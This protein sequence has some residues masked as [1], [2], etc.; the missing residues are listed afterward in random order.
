MFVASI[1]I[2]ILLLSTAIADQL[3]PSNEPLHWMALISPEFNNTEGWN[4]T[5]AYIANRY[6]LTSGTCVQNYTKF[7]IR[8]GA[9]YVYYHHENKNISK[10]EFIYDRILRTNIAYKHDSSDKKLT[11]LLLEDDEPLSLKAYI[12]PIALPPQPT[13]VQLND[14]LD[15]NSSVVGWGQ[16]TH[17][18]L[19]QQ[20]LNMNVFLFLE[21]LEARQEVNIHIELCAA[22]DKLNGK[23][24]YFCP[25]VGFGPLLIT[26]SSTFALIG[27]GI[28]N[29][30]EDI[31]QTFIRIN[32][33]RKW[34]DEVLSY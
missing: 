31:P 2:G 32:G 8:L 9:Y 28:D 19:N 25:R 33:Y 14:A 34:I 17:G 16:D 11:I 7:R 20:E 26:K 6:V 27:I 1:F 15:T 21:C 23:Y 24:L 13:L 12:R 18:N 4:C 10:L 29:C 3:T 22:G 5:G 30:V